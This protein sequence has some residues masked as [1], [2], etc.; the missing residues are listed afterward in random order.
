MVW[1]MLN[2]FRTAQFLLGDFLLPWEI[3]IGAVGFLAAWLLLVVIEGL[4]WS[5]Y[6]WNV[7]LLFIALAILFGSALG[8]CLAP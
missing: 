8:L 5:R 7:P 6:L 4:G 1:P 2:Q 3:L